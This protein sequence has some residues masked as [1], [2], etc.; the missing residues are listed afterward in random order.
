MSPRAR[1]EIRARGWKVVEGYSLGA[2]R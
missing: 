2:A 1:Q